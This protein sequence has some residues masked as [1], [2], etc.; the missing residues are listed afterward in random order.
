MKRLIPLLLC[1]ALLGACSGLP[2]QKDEAGEAA[3]RALAA[4]RAQAPAL[5]SDGTARVAIDGVEIEK[6]PFRAGVSSATVE[7]MAAQRGCRGG[8]GA[9]LVT[10]PGPVEVYR[11]ACDDGAVFM[12]R[13]ELR[14]CVPMR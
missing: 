1:A 9:G 13:C 8:N 6:I 3:A 12:A 4:R 7:R 14:Q 5:A 10:P 11:M 2:F